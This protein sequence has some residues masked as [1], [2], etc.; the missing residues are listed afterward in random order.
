MKGLG[1]RLNTAKEHNQK[2]KLS[3]TTHAIVGEPLAEL[4]DH[5]EEDAQGI[6][7]NHYALRGRGGSCLTVNQSY[8][9]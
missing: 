9:Y 2:Y 6:A 3:L 1:K 8:L 5:D 4:V 7:A